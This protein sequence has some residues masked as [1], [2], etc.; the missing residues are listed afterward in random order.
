VRLGLLTTSY[1]RSPGD[2]AGGFVAEHARWLAARGHRVEVIAAG[3]RGD[4]T[5]E[6]DAS[7]V[8][9]WR[10]AAA[11]G[12]FYA[13]GAPE[14]LA[15]GLSAR[16]L[17]AAAFGAAMTAAVARH[18]AA[19]DG[20]I[21]HWLVPSALAAALAGR[22]R[23]LLA[24]AH[25]GDVHLLCRARLATPVVALLR[26][27]RAQ[28]VF[29]SGDLRTRLVRAVRPSLR[30]GLERSR[31]H[32]MGIDVERF[33]RASTARP[34]RDALE[35]VLF[36]GRLVP[37]KGVDI[38]IE[39][40]AR[41][42][43]GARL[44]IA[45]TGP[46]EG[47]LRARAAALCPSRVEFAGEVRGAD[48][49]RLLASADALVLP[50]IHVEGRR[51]E[52]LPVAALEAMAARVPVVASRV[53]GLAEIPSDAIVGVAPGDAEALATAV[54]RLAADPTACERQIGAADAVA[55]AHDWSIAGPVFSLNLQ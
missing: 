48:R 55:E 39:A 21:A 8:R 32:A 36:L 45:G 50:S 47:R 2:P 28:V 30:A 27:A 24:I 12:L 42:Q 52:G 6:C 9:V 37:V 49:D 53:G 7:G 10:V 19:W 26:A 5:S 35:T 3:R 11:P 16:S 20:I 34:P 38:A 46:E 15:D 18:S 13:G 51:T 40:A 29:V 17:Q 23:P 1:P 41:W 4:V 44:V 22:R 31:V 33:R 14:A 43:C 54:D 25:S